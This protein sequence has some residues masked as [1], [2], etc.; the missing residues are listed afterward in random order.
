MP[1]APNPYDYLPAAPAMVL[2]STDF[3]E[4]STL[5]SP[6]L[7]KAFGV[8][9]GEDISPALSWSGAPDDTKS[10]V[11]TCYDPDAPTVSG[12]WHWIVYDI[13]ATVTSLV[14]GA[15]NPDI[16][17]ATTVYCIYMRLNCVRTVFFL[18]TL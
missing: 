6:Q 1:G 16:F 4:G 15:G 14:T 5:Q 11:V 13:P 3:E 12:F 2:T 9:G 8:D 18:F 10:F 17:T 7:S